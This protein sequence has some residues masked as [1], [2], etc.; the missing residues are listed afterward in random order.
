MT[1]LDH[2]NIRT[3]D[4]E[5]TVG[6]YKDVLDLKEGDFPGNR[7]MGAWLYDAT[8][9]AVLHIIWVN[10]ETP[11]TAYTQIRTRLGP[12]AGQLDRTTLK[13]GG[14]IDHIA[15]E[16][17]DYSAMKAKLQ[18]RGL[19]FTENYVESIGLRQLFANDP[20]GVTLEMNFRNA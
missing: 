8:D 1:K 16:C 19:T 13:G 9:R 20:S 17:T 15:F 3:F 7:S 2:C 18:K 12:L 10:P 11:D 14:A 6:F 5:A 4:L